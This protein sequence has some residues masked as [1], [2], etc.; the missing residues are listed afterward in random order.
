[1]GAW[2]ARLAGQW[3]AGKLYKK[4]FFLQKEAGW[5]Y[6]F[7]RAADRLTLWASYSQSLFSILIL[8]IYICLYI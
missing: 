3:P 4:V 2:T 5:P 7:W 6:D 8:Y 1:M